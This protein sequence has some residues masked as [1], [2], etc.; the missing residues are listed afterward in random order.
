MIQSNLNLF[1][2][3]FSLS[4]YSNF[5]SYFKIERPIFWTGRPIVSVINIV[6]FALST[7]TIRAP[8]LMVP[9]RWSLTNISFCLPQYRDQ[10]AQQAL[11]S[12]DF[13]G[14]LRHFVQN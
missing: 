4:L 14:T 2:R 1:D 6:L 7:L 11:I 13:T 3:D 5:A 8:S 12:V 10:L 9:A